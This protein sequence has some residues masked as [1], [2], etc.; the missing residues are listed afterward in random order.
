LEIADSDQVPGAFISIVP[1]KCCL[2]EQCEFSPISCR[3]SCRFFHPAI[4]FRDGYLAVI[5]NFATQASPL[6]D[7]F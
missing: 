5:G 1:M 2:S 4:A 3:V 6:P 7:A